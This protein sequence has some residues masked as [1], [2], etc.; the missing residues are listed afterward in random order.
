[1][2]IAHQPGSEP[3]EILPL[4]NASEISRAILTDQTSR[5]ASEH[6]YHCTSREY[7]FWSSLIAP[8][9]RLRS[10]SGTASETFAV[11]PEG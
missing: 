7:R 6:G 5:L 10:C 11:Q 9:M 4:P 2:N 3:L 1:M 8:R